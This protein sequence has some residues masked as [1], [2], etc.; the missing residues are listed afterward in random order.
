VNLSIE[1]GSEPI[2]GSVSVEA[3]TPRK[4][5]GWIELVAAIESVRHAASGGTEQTLGLIPGANGGRI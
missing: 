2:A 3:G 1:V 5:S 4:F